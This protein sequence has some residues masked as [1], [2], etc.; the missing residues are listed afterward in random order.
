[1]NR[2]NIVKD[3]VKVNSYVNA[4]GTIVDMHY[5]SWPTPH[6]HITPCH[7]TAPPAHSSPTETYAQAQARVAGEVHAV[8]IKQL[9]QSKQRVE[10][11]FSQMMLSLYGPLKKPGF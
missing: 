1:M 6:P 3:L 11:E 8:K 9:E 2:N 10:K 4:N 5:R 7:R